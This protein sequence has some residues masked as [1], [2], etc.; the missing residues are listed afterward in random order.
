MNAVKKVDHAQGFNEV[1]QTMA[2]SNIK[3]FGAVVFINNGILCISSI[4][5]T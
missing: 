5:D 2:V 3:Y 4:A 1:S